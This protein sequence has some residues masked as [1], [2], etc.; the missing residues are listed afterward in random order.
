MV[1]LGYLLKLFDSHTLLKLIPCCKDT[2][3]VFKKLVVDVTCTLGGIKIS[4]KLKN[5]YLLPPI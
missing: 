2:V 4:V 3:W 5:A 1:E